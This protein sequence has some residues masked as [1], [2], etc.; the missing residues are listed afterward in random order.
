MKTRTLPGWVLGIML[1]GAAPA[2]GFTAP[3]TELSST[4][5][6]PEKTGTA[7]SSPANT[8]PMA[9]SARADAA[10][11]LSPAA[12]AAPV[13]QAT[14]PPPAIISM[15]PWFYEVERLAKA[16]VEEGVV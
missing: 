10:S 4:A 1:A 5:V 12:S 3:A 11:E 9:P 16:G 7:I 15:S 2:L 13:H 6:S 14:K 8:A